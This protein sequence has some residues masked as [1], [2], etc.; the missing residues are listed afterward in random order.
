MA[1]E[2]LMKASE[3]MK[4]EVVIVNPTFMI[5]PYDTKPS[6]GKIILMGYNK[7]ISFLPPGG[8][9]FIHVKDA[10]A[11][12]CNALKYGKNRE[13]YLLCNENL[14]YREFFKLMNRNSV[15]PT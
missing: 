12:V 3:K 14:T 2:L 7:R 8:K 5:G 6:S 10:A 13:K 1:E 15:R 11:A 4:T 9:N